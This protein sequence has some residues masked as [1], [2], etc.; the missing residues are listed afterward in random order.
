M[1]VN[2]TASENFAHIHNIHNQISRINYCQLLSHFH[3][4]C[5]CFAYIS[6]IV[7]LCNHV[8]IMFILESS[9]Y[10]KNKLVLKQK[11]SLHKKT[12]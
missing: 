2:C 1:Y 6:P 8:S 3:N 4:Q 5:K 11:K 12:D 7:S 10:D 9:L